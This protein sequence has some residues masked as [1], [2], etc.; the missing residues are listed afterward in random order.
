MRFSKFFVPTTKNAPND[1]VLPSHKLLI[2]GG[3]ITQVGSGIYN[4]LPLGK[5][6][7][8]KI[9][10][11]VKEELD[12][13]SCQE[14]QLGFVTPSELWK[15]SGRFAKY[16]KE[17]LRFKDRKENEFVLSP[18]AEEMMVDLVRNRV[19]SY[20]QLPLHLYQINTKF[21]DEARPRF[22]LLRGRE[23]L[24][25]D[26]YSFHDSF[27]DLDR[28]FDLMEETYSKI[29]KRLGLDFRVV[30]A[31]SGAI[32][33]TGSKEFM[34]LADNG[35]DD[36]IV[37]DSCQNAA[38]I[39]V[40]KRKKR[41]SPYDEEPVMQPGEFYTP[42]TKTIESLAEFFM[43]E[44]YYLIKAVAKKAI[45]EN[46][47]SEVV[48]YFLR[49]DD[50]LEE[51]KAL[52]AVN[53]LEI[54][55]ASEEELEKLGITPGFIGPD[56]KNVKI[57]IDEELKEQENLICGANKKDYHFV[58]YSLKD[59][60]SDNYAD[61][62]EVREGDICPH[63][64]GVL[65]QT[66]GIEVG[67]IFKLGDRYSKP[68]KAEFLDQN[69]KSKP[70]I[71]GT[72][73]IGVSRLVAVIIE[74]S[75]DEKGCVWTKQSAP[76]MLDIIVSNIKNEEELKFADKIYDKLLSMGK[77]VIIDDRKERFGFKMKDFELIG[78][79]YALIVG[80][81]LKEGK[82]EVVDRK[83]LEKTTVDIDKI[84]EYLKE[85]I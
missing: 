3:F 5:I 55:D 27:E 16:G 29:F 1:A 48:I 76:F 36:I 52:N 22:G 63:C 77:E 28:E 85:L 40:A 44:P 30:D 7:L 9:R 24:M 8:D 70:F 49:G 34:V 61:I 68:M 43:I 26:G 19:K 67:H 66:K 35:E 54:E 15:E 14:V 47:E 75:H 79:P 6:V 33:G 62:A 53:A 74:Q 23:F 18:T 20:K 59:K 46:G 82:V 37:C 57:V 78:F 25:E 41:V 84:E 83:T 81:S 56:V 32:G 58:G 42:D 17:L 38:N 51:T 69:G 11:I 12:N 2:Q 72:Y 60:F 71:M 4:F 80:K 65:S 31:D 10:N 64:G 73:G 21:R 13:A 45:Y 39:E 50:S